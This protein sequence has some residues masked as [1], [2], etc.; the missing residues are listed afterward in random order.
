MMSHAAALP[1]HVLTPSMA[2]TKRS[3]LMIWCQ[4]G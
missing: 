1:T 3:T 2:W 4:F